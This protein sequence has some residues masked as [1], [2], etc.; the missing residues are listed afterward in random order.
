LD[1]ARALVADFDEPACVIVKHNNPC[2]VAIGSGTLDAYSKAF[3]C[4]PVSAYGGII[5]FNRPSDRAT[6]EQLSKQFIEVLIAPGYEEGALEVLTRKPNTR[7]LEDEERRMGR[8][9][10]FDVRQVTGGLLVQDR[11]AAA[12]GR[13]TME[14]VTKRQPTDQEWADLMFAWKVC[15]RV[16]S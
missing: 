14:V 7:I 10:D 13:E 5:A 9:V 2:G 11:D 12:E 1:S 3:A 15:A 8:D 6:A 4:D 16:K